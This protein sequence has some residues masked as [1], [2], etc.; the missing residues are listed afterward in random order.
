MTF[1]HCC[2]GCHLNFKKLAQ[3]R[4][5]YWFHCCSELCHFVYCL[6][7]MT[8]PWAVFHHQGDEYLKAEPMKKMSPIADGLFLVSQ[9]FGEVLSEAKMKCAHEFHLDCRRFLDRLVDKIHQNML[10]DGDDVLVFDLFAKLVVCLER[11]R[12][13]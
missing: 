9:A 6:L 12:L 10:L 7:G 3:R 8:R 2:C 4:D 13:L 11:F 1:S 5:D